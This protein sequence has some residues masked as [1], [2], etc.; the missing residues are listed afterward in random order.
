MSGIKIPVAGDYFMYDKMPDFYMTS[1]ESLPLGRPRKCYR[2]KRIHANRRDDY[3][4]VQVTPPLEIQLS[5]GTSNPIDELIIASRHKSESLF[6]IKKWPVT[7]YVLRPL[8]E[9]PKER[10][11]LKDD[12]LV[13]IGWAEIYDSENG[14]A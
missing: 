1:N 12:E 11:V 4:L 7:V 6:P 3:L 14:S 5:G 2:I 8:V 13:L 10:D 9:N